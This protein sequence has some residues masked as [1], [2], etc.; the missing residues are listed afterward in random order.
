MNVRNSFKFSKE[1]LCSIWSLNFTNVIAKCYFF[2]EFRIV[3]KLL[4]II[5]S[6]DAPHISELWNR[7]F[8]LCWLPLDIWWNTLMFEELST[9]W[10]IILNP[11]FVALI[12]EI[13]SD[14]LACLKLPLSLLTISILTYDLIDEKLKGYCFWSHKSIER[15]L[16]L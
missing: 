8:F 2:I 14:F 3:L 16:R 9:V 10:L 5:W 12:S 15:V 4:S 13:G 11:V 1:F 6:I 7:T